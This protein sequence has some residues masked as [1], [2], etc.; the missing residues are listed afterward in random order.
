MKKRHLFSITSKD[1]TIQR[2]RSGGKGGQHQ[3]KTETGIRIIH[4]ASGAK[5][6]SRDTRSQHQNKTIAFKRLVSSDKF[7]VWL[8]LHIAKMISG[9]YEIRKAIDEAMKPGNLKIELMKEGKWE[10]E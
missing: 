9:D 7:K 2:F 1:F 8:R 6:E 3:N 4:D 10:V 5:G